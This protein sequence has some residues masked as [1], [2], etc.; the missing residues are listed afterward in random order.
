MIK[1]LRI[2]LHRLRCFRNRSKLVGI[3]W[4]GTTPGFTIIGRKFFL[5]TLSLCVILLTVGWNLSKKWS[6]LVLADCV[7][8]AG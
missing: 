1:T 2:I 6:L 5:Q 4:D 7:Q 8:Y 3:A